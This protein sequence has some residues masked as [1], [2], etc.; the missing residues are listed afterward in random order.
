MQNT[1][2]S[3]GSPN[4]ADAAGL[5]APATPSRRRRRNRKSRRRNPS[6]TSRRRGASWRPPSGGNGGARPAR[7]RRRNSRS[8]RRTQRR[9]RADNPPVAT[10]IPPRA[11]E[12]A[13][14]PVPSPVIAPTT[15]PAPA[16]TPIPPKGLQP[17]PVPAP[18]PVLAPTRAPAPA[19]GPGFRHQ[20]RST[21]LWDG[22]VVKFAKATSFC[23]CGASLNCGF[24]CAGGKPNQVGQ[25]GE[26][27]CLEG[28]YTFD[29]ANTWTIHVKKE[30]ARD[31]HYRAFAYV[32]W[33]NLPGAVQLDFSFKAVGHNTVYTKIFTLGKHAP[34]REVYGLLPPT[35]PG[36]NSKMCFMPLI[37]SWTE[38]AC[39]GYNTVKDDT[40]YRV[41]LMFTPPQ[42]AANDHDGN[43]IGNIALNVDGRHVGTGNIE[44]DV[45]N[46]LAG[47]LD[48]MPRLGAEHRGSPESYKLLF[49]DICLHKL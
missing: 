7:R 25:C 34:V 36:T 5:R 16:V 41:E 24:V 49:R 33:K 4:T 8:R 38:P 30:E 2:S 44:G 40:W 46:Q 17:A 39:I 45:V 15:A 9:R 21:D 18:S 22:S 6:T 28:I 42:V 47:S 1:I 19:S 3:R 20:C 26:A 13:P 23:A 37:P 43:S 29:E 31:G 27:A 35:S 32:V 10:P 11:P 12:P 14:V 48:E